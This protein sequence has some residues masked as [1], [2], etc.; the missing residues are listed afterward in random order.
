M[1][2]REKALE[3]ARKLKK[4]GVNLDDLIEMLEE[5]CVAEDENFDDDV[6][7]TEI[8]KESGITAN[9]LGYKYLVETIKL[10]YNNPSR[11]WLHREIYP[12]IAEKFKVT[13]G[14]VER[15]IRNAIETTWKENVGFY[16]KILGEKALVNMKKPTNSVVIAAISQYYCM[17]RKTKEQ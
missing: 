11:V 8:M 7:I 10:A 13:T 2:K 5:I 15:A 4:A 9:Y 14:S 3:T 1:R 6:L 17:K 16:K 12:V